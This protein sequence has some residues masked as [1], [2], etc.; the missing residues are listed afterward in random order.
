MCTLLHINKTHSCLSRTQDTQIKNSGIFRKANIVP[1]RHSNIHAITCF[2]E[3]KR[4]AYTSKSILVFI[5]LE[6]DW[7]LRRQPQVKWHRKLPN[8]PSGFTKI[9]RF[10]R[11]LAFCR[12]M[13]A[14]PCAS[15]STVVIQFSKGENAKMISMQNGQFWTPC[16]NTFA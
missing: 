5:R 11:T 3:K 7:L 1:R 12:K 4:H 16:K 15:E 10:A 9:K 8:N 14:I 6:N 2:L 13:K